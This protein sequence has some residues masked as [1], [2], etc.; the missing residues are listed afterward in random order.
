MSDYPHAVRRSRA[1]AE[2]R[3]FAL[4]APHEVVPAAQ[5]A[6]R[7]PG[8]VYPGQCYRRAFLFLLDI[9]DDGHGGAGGAARLVHGVYCPHFAGGPFGHAW[10]DLGD[11][12]V[13]DGVLQA[14]YSLDG[15][16]AGYRATAEARYTVREAAEQLLAANHAGP[17]HADSAADR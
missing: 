10:V 2:I 15:Y 14:F 11:G 5:W 9:S 13:F 17:W 16:A 7:A 8:W 4:L 12:T 3:N 6:W 1:R